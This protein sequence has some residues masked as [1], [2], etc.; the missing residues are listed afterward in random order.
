MITCQAVHPVFTSDQW[1]QTN[2]EVKYKL[3]ILIWCTAKVSEVIP[4]CDQHATYKQTKTAVTNDDR[5]SNK[6]T[7]LGISSN[8]SFQQLVMILPDLPRNVCGRFK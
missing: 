2:N 8:F 7:P 1:R 5:T 3:N 6:D 4:F